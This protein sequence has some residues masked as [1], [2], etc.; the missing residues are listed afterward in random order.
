MPDLD[1]LLSFFSLFSQYRFRIPDYQ[2]GY[3]WGEKEHTELLDDIATLTDDNEH[4]TGLLV[5]HENHEPGL[6]VKTRGMVKPV[7]DVVDG[8]QRLTTIVILMSEIKRAMLAVGTPDLLEIAENIQRSYLFEPGSG[9]LL[10]PSLILDENN[11]EFFERNILEMESKS[12]LGAQIKSHD[13]LQAARNFFA[14]ELEKRQAIHGET[15]GEWLE[16]LYGKLNSQLKVMVYRLRSESDAGVVF[17]SM[18]S[19]G[20]KPNSMDLV[21]NY[22]LFAASKL[23]KEL[24]ERL[25]RDINRTWKTIFEQLSA[26]GRAENEETL[27]EFHWVTV[28]DHD[29]KRWSQEREKSDHI[30]KKFK[31]LVTNPEKH[32]ELFSLGEQYVQTLQNVVVAYTDIFN[33][34]R[35]GAFQIFETFPKIKKEIVKYSE[36]LVRIDALRSFTP[37]LISLRLRN[38]DDAQTYLDVLKLCEK[39]AFRA[40]RVAS[41]RVDSAAESVLFRLGNQYYNEKITLETLTES[42]QRDL[43]SRCSDAVFA[44]E[45]FIGNLKPWYGRNGLKYLLY[46][47]EEYLHGGQSPTINWASIYAGREKTIEHIL[48]QTPEAESEWLKLFTPALVEQYKHVLGNLTLTEDNS[49]LGRKSFGEKKGKPGQPGACYSNSNLKCERELA[50]LEK[51][52]LTSIEAR[53]KSLAAWAAERWFVAQPPPLPD[54]QLETLTQRAKANGL[55]AEFLKIYELAMRLNLFPKA[56]KNRMSYRSP[57]NYLWAVIKMYT[58]ASGIDLWLGFNHFPL[59][60]GVPEERIREIFNGQGHWWLPPDQIAIFIAR[61]E[62]LANEVDANKAQ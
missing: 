60:K 2:R 54:N 26:A 19:R 30:K 42:I 51:W 13:Y 22:L 25:G 59:Y 53:Q 11:R 37:L 58:Y 31:A 16:N 55:G 3:A 61:L 24:A 35:S 20:K 62:Q 40:F 4:F 36:K 9:S 28:Y 46:E 32:S 7:Y 18:N 34:S 12:L 23:E 48:P 29:R 14:S 49:K 38:P 10:V 39:Y 5:I 45:F 33:P 47:Y 17:E 21:K 44:Q 6:R 57:R 43:H 56:N 41:N 50:G 8:Q 27:L 1:N 15:Y 52:I